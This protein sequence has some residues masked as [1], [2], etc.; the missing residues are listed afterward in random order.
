MKYREGFS[1]ELV[2]L[3]L[4]KIQPMSILDPFSGI[5]TTPL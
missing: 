2:E 5:G 4:E 3:V 1:K